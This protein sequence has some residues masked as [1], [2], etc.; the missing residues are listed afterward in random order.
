MAQE[1]ESNEDEG[2]NCVP[3]VGENEYVDVD[4]EG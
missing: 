3:E 2:N 1:T 4:L